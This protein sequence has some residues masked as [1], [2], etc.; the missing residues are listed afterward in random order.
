MPNRCPLHGMLHDSPLLRARAQ[1]G[2]II[3]VGWDRGAVVGVVWLITNSGEE[4]TGG[5]SF[6]TACGSVAPIPHHIG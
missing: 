4:K 5:A 3:S 6:A 2:D 1:L